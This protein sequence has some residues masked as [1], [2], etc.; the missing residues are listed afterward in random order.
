MLL[1]GLDAQVRPGNSIKDPKFLDDGRIRRF[2]RVG[3]NFPFSE[4]NCWFN[5]K[6]KVDGKGK[7]VLKKNWVAAAGI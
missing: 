4:E 2:D 6:P 7:P 1:H 3:A 5:G